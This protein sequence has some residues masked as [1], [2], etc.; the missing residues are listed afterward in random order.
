[1]KIAIQN[2]TPNIWLKAIEPTKLMESVQKT[3]YIKLSST[4]KTNSAFD[5]FTSEAGKEFAQEALKTIKESGFN[6]CYEWL[7][8]SLEKHSNL[9]SGSFNLV[10]DILGTDKYLLRYPDKGSSWLI[11]RKN[12]LKDKAPHLAP[13]ENRFN[14]KVGEYDGIEIIKKVEGQQIDDESYINTDISKEMA[15]MPQK[16]FFGFIKEVDEGLLEGQFFDFI[17][18]NLFIDSKNKK[19]NLIDYMSTEEIER[20]SE[21]LNSI[22][23]NNSRE[24]AYTP[25]I[26]FMMA[27]KVD[28][29]NKL[30]KTSDKIQDCKTI[31]AK[32][33][34]V[35]MSDIKNIDIKRSINDRGQFERLEPCLKAA[36]IKDTDV[37]DIQSKIAEIENLKRKYFYLRKT[38]GIKETLFDKIRKFNHYIDDLFFK[39]DPKDKSSS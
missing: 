6:D 28:S 2:H 24:K 10:S 33:L 29:F 23:F 34:K 35:S 8:A 36:S 11:P 22:L 15:K 4:P 30:L 3:D 14:H 25:L 27:L 12:S 5:C 13:E 38:P 16:A 18:R 19:F 39:N 17:G 20:T 7:L 37:M 21:N 1:M 26:A 32:A 9:K 31:V